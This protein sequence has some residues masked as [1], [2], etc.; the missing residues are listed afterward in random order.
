MKA[1]VGSLTHHDGL[2]GGPPHKVAFAC[3][4]VRIT[5]LH[6]RTDLTD[7]VHVASLPTFRQRSVNTGSNQTTNAEQPPVSQ[8]RLDFPLATDLP[9]P[10]NL[11]SAHQYDGRHRTQPDRARVSRPQHRHG[12]RVALAG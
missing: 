11:R 5:L 2:V 9:F 7:H 12:Q 1:H 8:H 3:A 6:P 4:P 10:Q